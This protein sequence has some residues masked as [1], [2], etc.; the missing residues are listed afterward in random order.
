MQ[1]IAMT[2]LFHITNFLG[3]GVPLCTYLTFR[4]NERHFFINKCCVLCMN[5]L[6]V[7]LSSLYKQVASS[8][9]YRFHIC[10]PPYQ[11]VDKP[12]V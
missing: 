1:V 7:L 6:K 8:I 5:I 3:V 10:T 12:C 2:Y 4:I 9:S 11:E